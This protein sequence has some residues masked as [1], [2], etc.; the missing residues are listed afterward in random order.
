MFYQFLHSFF[1]I[2]LCV[3]CPN[4]FFMFWNVLLVFVFCNMSSVDVCFDTSDELIHFTS[5][6]EC[7]IYYKLLL[8]SASY[9]QGSF[10]PKHLHVLKYGYFDSAFFSDKQNC[11]LHP[12]AEL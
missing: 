4:M 1:G 10:L 9:F 8:L 6:V 11:I 3:F 5:G 12:G 7:S 2:H